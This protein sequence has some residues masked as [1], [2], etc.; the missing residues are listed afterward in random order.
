M[1][2]INSITGP[3]CRLCGYALKNVDGG[4]ELCIRVKRNLIWPV[5]E[6]T[7][8]I[9]SAHSTIQEL[10]KL[11]KGRIKK[12][13]AAERSE[14][15]YDHQLTQAITA[16]VRAGKELA[17]EARKLEDRE[18]LEYANLGIEGRMQLFVSE[19]FAALPSDFQIKLLK[20]MKEVWNEQNQALLPEGE[21]E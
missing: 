13:K 11:V 16:L 8:E 6:N 12:V 7:S 19:F 3:R 2:D 4:C 17:A 1:S 21:S 15:T 20:Q 9:A 18:E 10:L 14:T 5:V